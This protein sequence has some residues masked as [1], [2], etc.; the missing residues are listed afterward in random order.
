MRIY[1]T[2]NVFSKQPTKEDD[3]AI[4]MCLKESGCGSNYHNIGW[5]NLITMLTSW[6]SQ[7]LWI[8]I[9]QVVDSYLKNL[10]WFKG[11][12]TAGFEKKIVKNLMNKFIG[13]SGSFKLNSVV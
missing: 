9:I 5:G 1:S 7:Q 4:V 6:C 8:Y 2:I 11:L 10:R 3:D 12:K 13:S